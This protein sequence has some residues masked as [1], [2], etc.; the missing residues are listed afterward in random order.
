[1]YTADEICKYFEEHISHVTAEQDESG[2]KCVISVFNGEVDDDVA[3]LEYDDRSA[4]IYNMLLEKHRI[5]SDPLDYEFE[6]W[7]QDQDDDIDDSIRNFIV[8]LIDRAVSIIELI[9]EDVYEPTCE[10]AKEFIK[11][12]LSEED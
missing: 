1:M 7:L 4:E 9:I 11:L 12:N 2:H 3:L 6:A 10:S 5:N 8:F